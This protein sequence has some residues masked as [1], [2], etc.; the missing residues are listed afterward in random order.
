MPI[1]LSNTSGTGNFRLTNNNNSG[2]FSLSTPNLLLDTYSGAS[3]ALSLRKLRDAYTGACIRVERSSDSTQQDIG[4]S[5]N[6]LDTDALATFVGAGT[7]TVVTWYD[8]T[9]NGYNVS[10][11]SLAA[12][13]ITVTGTNQTLNSKIAINFNGTQT[14][15]GG[16][17][18]NIMASNSGRT[19]IAFGVGNVTDTNTRLM[20]FISGATGHSQAIRRN[21]TAIEAIAYNSGTYTDAA[22]INPGTSQFI[23]C[24]QRRSSNIEISVN[25]ST[26]GATNTTGTAAYNNPIPVI[27]S[28]NPNS[29]PSFAW[30]GNMQEVIMFAVDPVTNTNYRNDITTAMNLYYTTY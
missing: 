29:G 7:G 2:N 9:T 6:F 25:N 22:G 4:F 18:P 21:S 19:F 17:C 5:G 28:F 15:L 8:Q 16:V 26:N 20:V 3:M 24:T 27:G 11:G 1:T 23:A 13:R 30:S 14:L 10:K 12:P